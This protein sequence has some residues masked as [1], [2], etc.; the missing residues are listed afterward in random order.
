MSD[1]GWIDRKTHKMKARIMT[2]HN[3]GG[4]AMTELNFDWDQSGKITSSTQVMWQQQP[5]AYASNRDYSMVSYGTR[6]LE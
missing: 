6:P 5:H 1:G 4:M 3:T 2:V